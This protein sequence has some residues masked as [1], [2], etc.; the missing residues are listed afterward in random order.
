MPNWLRFTRLESFIFVV[1]L[2]ALIALLGPSPPVIWNSNIR[3]RLKNQLK[4]ICTEIIAR[5]QEPEAGPVVLQDILMEGVPHREPAGSRGVS[6]LLKYGVTARWRREDET[7]VRVAFFPFIVS[8]DLRLSSGKRALRPLLVMVPIKDADWE[9]LPYLSGCDDEVG[10]ALDSCQ[11]RQ[12]EDRFR[13]RGVQDAT[14]L[15]SDGSVTHAA[16]DEL[17]SL[18]RAAGP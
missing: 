8:N 9:T 7:L 12:L 11:L 18:C 4:E 6:L 1:I 16:I 2:V 14:V 15:M 13:S 17:L 3:E 10:E 5:E